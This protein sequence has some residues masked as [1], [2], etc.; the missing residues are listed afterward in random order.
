MLI[1][2][3]LFA[4]FSSLVLNSSHS[5]VY[6]SCTDNV[7]YTFNCVG[8]NQYPVA[9]YMG[10]SA[11]SFYVKI[12]L[13]SDDTFLLSGSSDSNAYIWKVRVYKQ[14][15]KFSEPC[16]VRIIVSLGISFGFKEFKSIVLKGVKSHLIH[17]EK[18]G[19]TGF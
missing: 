7:I 19:K 14:V 16:M 5:C 8:V 6:A 4:G 18:N 1:L 2:L 17:L 10:H 15:C 9:C 3:F 11:A 12:A 13:S